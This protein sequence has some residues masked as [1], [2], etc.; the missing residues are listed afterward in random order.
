MEDKNMEV[1]KGL[2]REIIE[3]R[4]EHFKSHREAKRLFLEVI[5]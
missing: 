4:K 5:L 3:G 2:C 1:Y